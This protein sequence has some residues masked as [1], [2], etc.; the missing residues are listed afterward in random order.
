[1]ERLPRYRVIVYIGSPLSA[2][3]E[4]DVD[5]MQLLKALHENSLPAHSHDAPSRIINIHDPRHAQEDFGR[6][7][8][9][10]VAMLSDPTLR[11]VM[12]QVLV[13]RHERTTLTEDEQRLLD[14]EFGD[15]SANQA[16]SGGPSVP[17]FEEDTWEAIKKR[18][19]VIRDKAA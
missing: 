6:C 7:L 3:S 12:F 15:M 13:N 5:M 9:N 1:M 18:F 4:H 16:I 14:E 2:K 8:K 11:G 17:G 19:P 10:A